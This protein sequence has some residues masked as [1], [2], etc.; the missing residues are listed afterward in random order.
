[1]NGKLNFDLTIQA[2]FEKSF[3]RRVG[4][5]VIKNPSKKRLD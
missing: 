4:N 3:A 1:M 5:T 2:T